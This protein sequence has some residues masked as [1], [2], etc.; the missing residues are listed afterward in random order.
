MITNQYKYRSAVSPRL[1]SLVTVVAMVL[2]EFTKPL[3]KRYHNQCKDIKEFLKHVLCFELEPI[4]DNFRC[5]ARFTLDRTLI[6]RRV[7]IYTSNDTY[8]QFNVRP[9]PHG[10][11]SMWRKNMQTPHTGSRLG[12]AVDRSE[13]LAPLRRTAK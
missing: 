13:E 8:G 7:T 11:L 3:A 6:D 4:P 12:Q 10:N 5:K 9:Y 1:L 2:K